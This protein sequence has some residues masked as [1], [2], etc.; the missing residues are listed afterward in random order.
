MVYASGV[1]ED[2]LS[3]TQVV[4]MLRATFDFIALGTYDAYL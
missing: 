1:T 4:S 2:K 3:R